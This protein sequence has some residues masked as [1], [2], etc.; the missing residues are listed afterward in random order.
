MAEDAEDVEL[1][2]P[3]EPAEEAEKTDNVEEPVADTETEDIE[4]IKESNKRLFERAKKAEAEAKLLKA[5]R[6]KAEEQAKVQPINNSD[7]LLREE[8]ILIAQGME[9]DDLDELKAVAK[10][11]DLSLLKAKD[12]PLFQGYLERAEA[13]RKKEKAKLSASRGSSV[14][15]EKSITQLTR[16]EHEALAKEMAEKI[17]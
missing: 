6:L 1:D 2:T 8:G 10:A 3:I 4:K 12:T 5:E 9:A 7:Y 14:K 16:E 13:D 11:K 15:Q 17:R